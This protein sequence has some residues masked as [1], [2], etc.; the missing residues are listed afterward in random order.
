MWCS[1]WKVFGHDNN[2]CISQGW[3]RHI[4][5]G[6][7]VVAMNGITNPESLEMMACREG[8][9]LANDLYLSKI[10]LMTKCTN[11]VCAIKED[12]M[13]WRWRWPQANTLVGPWASKEVVDQSATQQE[14]SVIDQIDLE[15]DKA[16]VEP[17]LDWKSSR[18]SPEKTRREGT[19]GESPR[20]SKAA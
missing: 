4:F 17:I 7:S 1:C 2:C 19:H 20:T 6:V 3:C 8:L 5:L 15:T 16:D 9:R 11:V 18:T 14:R 13:C 12:G 10:K